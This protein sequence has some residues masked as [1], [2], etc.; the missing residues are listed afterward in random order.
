MPAKE[1]SAIMWQSDPRWQI[2]LVIFIMLTAALAGYGIKGIISG[3]ISI[4]RRVDPIDLVEYPGCTGRIIALAVTVT[5]LAA[6]TAAFY[7]IISR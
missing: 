1:D 2:I 6:I 7:L 4:P 5:A 3:R